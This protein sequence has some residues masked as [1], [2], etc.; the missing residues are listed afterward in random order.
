MNKGRQGSSGK[1]ERD[2]RLAMALKDNIRR[3][4]D[5]ARARGKQAPKL[6]VKPRSGDGK[7]AP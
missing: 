2:K 1:M 4:K 6:A 5:Q 7:D 3:R